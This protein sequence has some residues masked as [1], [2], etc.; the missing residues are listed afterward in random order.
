M[1][2]IIPLALYVN[3]MSEE[4][5]RPETRC[6]LDI[7][8]SVIIFAVSV[9]VIIMS[10]VYWKDDYVDEFYYSSGLMPFIIGSALLLMSI[11]YFYR[12]VKE[13]SFSVCI[14]DLKNFSLEF[15]K[16]KSVHKSLVILVMFFIYIYFM[17]GKLPFAIATFIALS[18]ILIFVNF[19]K[20]WK[21]IL[22]MV[23]ISACATGA[24][25]LVFQVIF[26]VPMP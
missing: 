22:K 2:G 5:K 12:T 14:K 1:P 20:S 6:G 18:A 23:V 24:I 9:Y 3:T 10:F 26:K 15:I 4:K 19:E 21:R 11:I 13:H 17:V 16:S 8:A 25:I 7:L